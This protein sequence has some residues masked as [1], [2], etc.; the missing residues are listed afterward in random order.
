MSYQEL[1]LDLCENMTPLY[2]ERSSA[3]GQR[4]E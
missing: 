1:E 2:T 3:S 4:Q